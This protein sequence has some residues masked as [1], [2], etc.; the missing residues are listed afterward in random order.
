MAGTTNQSHDVIILG[1]GLSGIYSLIKTRERLP[2]WKVRVL[3]AGDDVGG[4]WNWNRYPG[5]RF[6]SESLSY[7]YSFDQDLLDEWHWK[8][9]FSPQPETLKYIQ[10]VAEKHDVYKDVTFNT[11]IKSA[12]W[13]ETSRTWTFVD[14]QGSM[15]TSRF[16]ISCLGFLSSPT[17]PNVSGIE[18]FQGQAFHT[19]RWPKD[20]DIRQSFAGKRIG[21]I[22]TGATG[23]QLITALSKAPKIASLEVFQGTPNWSAP[24]RNREITLEEMARYRTEYPAIFERCAETPTC[25]LHQADPRKSSEISEE[26]RL[27]LWE[28]LY[29][30]PGFAKWLGVFS[31]TYTDRVA[32]AMYSEFIADKI[33]QRVHDPAVAESLIPKNHGFG[34]RRVP[35]ES[36]Y[37]E[38]FNKPNVHLVDLQQTPISRV[39]PNGINTSDGKEHNLDVL[40]YATGFDAI[41]GAFSADDLLG[42]IF[43]RFCIGK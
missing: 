34:T 19:S 22:G 30:E 10:R 31:D 9:T 35:L 3:E 16:F 36:G 32:N 13:E 1:A 4:T 23:I 5:C 20:L 7:S 27:T 21:V 11:R 39:T 12:H 18:N 40:I 42:E 2:E 26:E 8:E 38:A 17:L 43:G 15:H 24:L 37:F 28:K 25:F 33:R 6:D 14:E 41:T 29:A